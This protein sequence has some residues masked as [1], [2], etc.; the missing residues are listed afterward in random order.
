MH[1]N[2]GKNRAVVPR[3]LGAL[4]QLRVDNDPFLCIE[5]RFA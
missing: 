2:L 4:S 3:E 1:L 5:Q